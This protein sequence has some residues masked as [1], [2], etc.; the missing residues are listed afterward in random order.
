MSHWGPVVEVVRAQPLQSMEEM[1]VYLL[2]G[3]QHLAGTLMTEVQ[4]ASRSCAMTGATSKAASPM[5]FMM[6]VMF[7]LG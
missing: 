3:G 2:F 1:L 6:G 4:V 7:A 5:V